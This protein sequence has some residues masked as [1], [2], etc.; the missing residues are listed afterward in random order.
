[1]IRRRRHPQSE[2]IS[3]KPTNQNNKTQ[4]NEQE[5]TQVKKE[6]EE[7]VRNYWRLGRLA[8]AVQTTIVSGIAMNTHY[9]MLLF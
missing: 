4:T 1:M 3:P 5:S 2:A 6:L 9:F 8:P 7:S